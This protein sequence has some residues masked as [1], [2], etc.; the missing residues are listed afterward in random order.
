MT[1]EPICLNFQMSMLWSVPGVL[2]RRQSTPMAR[3]SF[4]GA[5]GAAGVPKME[6]GRE[7]HGPKSGRIVVGVVKPFP[8]HLSNVPLGPRRLKRPVQTVRPFIVSVYTGTQLAR[9]ADMIPIL[10]ASFGI[11]LLARVTSYGRSMIGV[12]YFYETT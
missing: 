6:A 9:A 8:S 4:A 7:M 3:A 10:A 2:V 5:V 11:R 12:F 1:A